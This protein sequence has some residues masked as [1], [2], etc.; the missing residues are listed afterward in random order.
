[1]LKNKTSLGILSGLTAGAFWG[2][3]FVYPLFSVGFSAMEQ[4]LNRYLPYALIALIPVLS[5]FRTLFKKT[6]TTD[7]KQLF[8]LAL[9]GNV[10]YYPLLSI[11]VLWA[12]G[13]ATSLIIGLIPVA[14]VLLARKEHDA[15]PIKHM[16]SSLS[17]ILLG[18]LFVNLAVFQAD[19]DALH[20]NTSFWQKII[21]LLCAGAAMLLWAYYSYANAR[22]LKQRTHFSDVQWGALTGITTGLLSLLTVPIGLWVYHQFGDTLLSVHFGSD[23]VWTPF[24]I[25]GVVLAF[26]ASF[27]GALLWNKASRSLPGTLSGQL[28]VSETVFALIYVFLWE[29]RWP[30][31]LEMLAIVFLITGIIKAIR[32]H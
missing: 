24:L 28:I 31:L 17:L 14:V 25:A 30:S 32:S 1:M 5:Q 13:A 16:I 18:V 21:G 26:F 15:A 10:L 9:T 27:V 20:A 11:G 2:A 29:A 22:A 3:I 8:V 12:G 6:S 23:R 4:M 7:W 19:S